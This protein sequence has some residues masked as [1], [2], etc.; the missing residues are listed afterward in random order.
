MWE[1][2]RGTKVQ[3]RCGVELGEKIPVERHLCGETKTRNRGGS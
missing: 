1:M 2:G 3:S